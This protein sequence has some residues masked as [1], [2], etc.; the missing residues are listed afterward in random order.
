GGGLLHHA[1]EPTGLH[2][3]AGGQS[4]VYGNKLQFE[5]VHSIGRVLDWLRAQF[6]LLWTAEWDRGAR[7]VQLYGCVRHRDRS[8]VFDH[9]SNPIDNQFRRISRW[10]S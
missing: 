1:D 9:K 10:Y 8:T 3:G 4:A 2:H 5:H 6:K 7:I